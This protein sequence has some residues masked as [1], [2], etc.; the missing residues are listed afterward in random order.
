MSAQRRAGIGD[1]DPRLQRAVEMRRANPK[2]G[3]QSIAKE[4]GMDTNRARAAMVEAGLI[5]ETDPPVK[6]QHW[7][8]TAAW[9]RLNERQR[10]QFELLAIRGRCSEE[11]ARR[12]GADV[13]DVKTVRKVRLRYNEA[14]RLAEFRLAQDEPE[15]DFGARP[16]SVSLFDDGNLLEQ[17][18]LNHPYGHGEPTRETVHG[19]ASSHSGKREWSTEQC[20]RLRAPTVVCTVSMLEAL[21]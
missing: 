2:R 5:E 20:A 16:D 12:I 13:D 9:G 6:R 15:T 14:K 7:T 21:A 10:T 11:I 3:Y 1:D 18:R 4:L 8:A 19:W 17:L